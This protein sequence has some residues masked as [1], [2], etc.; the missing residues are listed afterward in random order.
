MK[1]GE[2]DKEF[3]NLYKKDTGSF[4]THYAATVAG[5]QIMQQAI[6]KAGTLDKQKVKQILETGEF[7]CLLYPKVKYVSEKGYTNLNK[8]A[9]TGVLQWQDGNL[10]TVYPHSIADKK[11]LY[12][13][14]W[15]K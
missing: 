10:L 3:V 8:Y 9:F 11:F 12:P 7:E 5:G 2:T 1:C 13:M 14:P 15:K 4:P 6:E